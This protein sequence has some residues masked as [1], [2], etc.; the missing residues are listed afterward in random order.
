[1]GICMCWE[2]EA[3]PGGLVGITLA[4]AEVNAVHGG[5]VTQCGLILGR[6]PWNHVTCRVVYC[7]CNIVRSGIPVKVG[8]ICGHSELQF[9]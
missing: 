6:Q 5:P 3:R 4:H 2:I 1:M 7:L 9:V 8:P